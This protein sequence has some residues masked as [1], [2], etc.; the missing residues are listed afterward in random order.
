MPHEIS[1]AEVPRLFNMV[2]TIAARMGPR[3]GTEYFAELVSAGCVG[4][5][6]AAA[7]FD[8]SRGVPFGKYAA[9]KVRWAMIDEIERSRASINT[10]PIWAFNDKSPVWLCHT[11]PDL[12]RRMDVE[13]MREAIDR[14]PHR[15]AVVM[16][17][18]AIGSDARTAARELGISEGSASYAKRDGMAA[19]KQALMRGT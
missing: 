10:I 15:Q 13:I 16:R 9:R 17:H 14:L 11:T 7:R 12:A 5:M 3:I 1:A 6:D 19:L 4:L 18:L 8:P 2:R